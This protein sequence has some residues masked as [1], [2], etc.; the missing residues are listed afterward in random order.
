MGKKKQGSRV[1]KKA[2][3]SRGMTAAD[4]YCEYY[5]SGGR[6][7]ISGNHAASG[8]YC[9]SY[10][11]GDGW[12]CTEASYT[13]VSA[14]PG[15]GTVAML[16]VPKNTG[17]YTLVERILYLNRTNTDSSHYCPPV[18][19]LHE[20]ARIDKK[21]GRLLESCA[22]ARYVASVTVFVKAVRLKRPKR[23]SPKSAPRSR[24]KRRKK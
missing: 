11:G 1:G 9:P 10:L 2:K 19:S 20:A 3:K 8:Y 22:R 4:N 7:A 18:L 23:T 21:V 16:A 5:C 12:G 6:W 24:G 15:S 14:F 13:T 17:E